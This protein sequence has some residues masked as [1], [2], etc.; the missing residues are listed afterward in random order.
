MLKRR[1]LLELL[2]RDL[3]KLKREFFSNLFDSAFVLLTILVVFGYFMAPYGLGEDYGPFIL[4]SAIA[5]F[6]FFGTVGKVFRLISDIDGDRTISYTLTLP[7]PSWLVFSYIGFF[8]ALESTIMSVFLF[9]LGKLILYKQ[10][11]LSQISLWKLV[12]MYLTM[13]IFYGFFSLWMCGILKKIG[14]VEH[15]W[16]RVI[17]PIIMF[18]A[19][20]NSWSAMY[21]VAP[22]VALIDLINPV[23]YVMEGMRTAGLGLASPI[24]FW[25]CLA[26]LWAFIIGCAWHGTRRLQDRLDCVR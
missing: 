26:V 22:T 19:F 20:Y 23:V 15:L 1:A 3:T 16:I 21:H 17:N 10:F 4:F 12:P 5:S 13:N 6:G 25:A 2:K 8:W 9:P 18:G 24:P 11:D 7:L 14:D